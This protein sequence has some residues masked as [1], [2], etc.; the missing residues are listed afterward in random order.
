MLVT[1]DV[2]SSF[3][4]KNVHK[5][6]RDLQVGQKNKTDWEFLSFKTSSET[7]YHSVSLFSPFKPWEMPQSQVSVQNEHL[8]ALI[9]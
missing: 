4:P 3:L 6:D 2:F 8:P 7:N 1:A 9:D 5:S